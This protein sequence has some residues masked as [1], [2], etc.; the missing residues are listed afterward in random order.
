MHI[1]KKNTKMF[2]SELRNLTPDL[3]NLEVWSDF[4]QEDVGYT[5]ASILT[6]VAEQ[7]IIW[8]SQGELKL[9]DKLFDFF[10]RSY[11]EFEDGSNAYV[12][13]DFHPTI[14]NCQNSEI[15]EK[16][17]SYMRPKTMTLYNQLIELG[18]YAEH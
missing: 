8:T 12:Y 18:F 16:I 1:K 6:N 17:K 11:S 9:I 14:I 13:T 3:K 5:G 4:D 2:Y 15:R 7:A 10:E